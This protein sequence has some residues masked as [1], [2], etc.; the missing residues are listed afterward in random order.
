M[1]ELNPEVRVKAEVEEVVR[2]LAKELGYQP[3]TIRNAAILYGLAQIALSRRIPETDEEFRSVI[4]KVRR[5]VGH[6]KEGY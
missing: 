6:A 1:Y 3:Y 4:K 2:E 5:L